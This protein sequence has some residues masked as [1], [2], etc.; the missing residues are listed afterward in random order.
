[1]SSR[2]KALKYTSRGTTY[3][4]SRTSA[5]IISITYQHIEPLNCSTRAR[6]TFANETASASQR[7]GLVTRIRSLSND[8]LLAARRTVASS[9][10]F[11]LPAAEHAASAVGFKAFRG[12]G[13]Y[14][15]KRGV[16]PL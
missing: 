2:E 8:T 13:P 1:M 12:S 5:S 14:R 6:A 7:R 4:Q 15:L 16:M 11:L 10:Q 3:W 9:C